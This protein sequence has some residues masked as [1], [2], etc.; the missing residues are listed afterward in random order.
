LYARFPT[1]RYFRFSIHS[2]SGETA[3][4]RFTQ[5]EYDREMALMRRL[6]TP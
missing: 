1:N 5:I 2:G 3:L 6:E 4:T